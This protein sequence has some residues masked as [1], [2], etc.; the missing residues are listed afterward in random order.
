MNAAKAVR[1][2]IQKCGAETVLKK[3]GKTYRFT[4]C[5]MPRVYTNETHIHRKETYFGREDPRRFVY[6]GPV[7]DGGEQAGDGDVILWGG[8]RYLLS[9]C[10]DFIFQGE[11]IFRRADARRVYGGG[12]DG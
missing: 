9:V 3:E 1:A 8:E 10:H 6:Y 2:A 4:A 5:V 7:A 11:K 12:V